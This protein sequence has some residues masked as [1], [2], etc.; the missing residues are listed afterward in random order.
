MER[1]YRLLEKIWYRNR[2]PQ[3]REI[4]VEN[5]ARCLICMD[6]LFAGRKGKVTCTC[7]NLTISGGNSKLVREFET[8]LWAETSKR[9]KVVVR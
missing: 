1:M 2:Y 6:Q 7:G 5:S 9:T 4:I 3:P 8:D